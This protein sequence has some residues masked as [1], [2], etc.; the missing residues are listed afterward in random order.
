MAWSYADDCRVVELSK[1]KKS[2][3]EAALIYRT[4]DRCLLGQSSQLSAAIGAL[5]HHIA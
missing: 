1:A 4:S 3:E 2:L 5:I